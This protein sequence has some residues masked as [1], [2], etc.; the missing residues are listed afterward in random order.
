MLI[1]KYV[2]EKGAVPLN[3]FNL[4]GYYLYELVDRDMVRNGNNNL[5]KRCDEIWVFGEVS[6]GVLAEIEI[7]KGLGRPIRYFDISSLPDSIVEISKEQ[8]VLEDE[9]KGLKSHL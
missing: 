1:C 7:F 3:P 8:V 6:D 2:F 4:F 9:V 5:L